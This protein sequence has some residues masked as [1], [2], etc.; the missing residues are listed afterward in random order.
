MTLLKRWS[1]STTH[2]EIKDSSVFM[3]LTFVSLPFHED[4]Y[5][6]ALKLGEVPM[7]Q[8]RDAA[9]IAFEIE[10]GLS[11]S[12]IE[13]NDDDT[14]C[15]SCDASDNVFEHYCGRCWCDWCE[16]MHQQANIG[17]KKRIAFPSYELKKKV[18]KW[19]HWNLSRKATWH[20]ERRCSWECVLYSRKFQ[21][22]A[23]E[24]AKISEDW[25]TIEEKKK[26]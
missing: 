10:S 5:T 25:G 9:R 13:G 7:Q 22:P 4:L 8:Q 11:F 17:A 15:R 20:L 16:Q 3:V 6:I 19:M 12:S 14:E 21:Q 2:L 26:Q 18:P 24:H 1:F 23:H